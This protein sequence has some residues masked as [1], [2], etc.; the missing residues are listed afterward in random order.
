MIDMLNVDRYS[1]N[2]KVGVN[3]YV[4]FTWI[5]LLHPQHYFCANQVKGR[6]IRQK[7]RSTEKINIEFIINKMIIQTISKLIEYDIWMVCDLQFTHH[8]I[9]KRRG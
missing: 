2:C 7:N 6:L 4:A 9:Q 1:M 5:F 8:G 3:E